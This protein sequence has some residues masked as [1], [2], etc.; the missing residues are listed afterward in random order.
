MDAWL[1]LFTVF[2]CLLFIGWITYLLIEKKKI[3][4][5]YEEYDKFRREQ[6][7]LGNCGSYEYGKLS[8]M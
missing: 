2:C 1:I 4:K 3:D 5:I 7:F 6:L 8:K